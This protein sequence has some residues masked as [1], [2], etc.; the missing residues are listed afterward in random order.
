MVDFEVSGVAGAEGG[1]EFH[2]VE[3]SLLA[4]QFL[5]LFHRCLDGLDGCVGSHY[6]LHALSDGVG[7]LGGHDAVAS[8]E[9]AV[10]SFGDGVFDAE[11]VVRVELCHRFGEHHGDGSEVDAAS[12]GV[13]DVNEFY[14]FRTVDGVVEVFEFVVDQ[15]ADDSI[16]ERRAALLIDVHQCGAHLDG[17]AL[18]EVAAVDVNEVLFH[19]VYI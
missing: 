14:L 9:G 4:E 15:C 19:C 8:V 2:A 10:V 12:F 1:E 3:L 16:G 5:H 18:V 6:L 17:E 11:V 13:V 7:H